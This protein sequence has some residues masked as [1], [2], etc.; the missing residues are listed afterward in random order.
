M[1]TATVENPK[2]VLSDEKGTELAS[3]DLVTSGTANVPAVAT[4][5]V[6]DI[7]P[8]NLTLNAPNLITVTGTGLDTAGITVSVAGNLIADA[9]ITKTATAL[10]FNHTPPA[11]G[12]IPVIVADANGN[13]LKTKSLTC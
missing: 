5:T 3:F 7:Q 8:D 11:N 2:L 12:A 13:V 1:Y 6:T 10:T 4:V 9:D